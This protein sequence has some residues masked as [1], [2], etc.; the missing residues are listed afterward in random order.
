MKTAPYRGG[1]DGDQ[2]DGS[3]VVGAA[4]I[5][6]TY[7]RHG[8]K[9]RVLIR[10]VN[11][12]L[13][14]RV[15]PTQQDAIDLVRHF[16]RLGMAGVD[17]GQALAEARSTTRRAY[18]PLRDAL[19]ASLDEQVALRNL[20]ESTA[21]AYKNRLAMWV[22]PRLGE[23]PW[24]LISREEIGAIL[25]AIRKAG[26]S[27]A[28]VEQVRCP[29]TRFYQW[30][31]NV[32][33]YRGPNLAADLRFFI[34]KQPSKRARKRDLQWFRQAQTLLEACRELKPRWY[35]FLM[36]SFGGGLRW[37]EA[38]ALYKTD[39]DWAR[40]RVHVQ[41]TW[42]ED[43]GR[44]EPCKDGEDRWVK[45]PPSVLAALRVHI[46][47]TDLEGSLKRWPKERRQLVF[48]NTVGRVTRYGAFLELVW[49][50][51]LEA[52]KLPYRKPHAVRH[53]YA[54][55]MLEEG[56]DL[57]YVKDQLGHTS[58]EETE[59]TYGHLE[60]ERHEQRVDLDRVLAP[61]S[62]AST[63]VHA[64]ADRA[65]ERDQVRDFAS[66][67]LMVEGKGFEPSTSALRTPRSPN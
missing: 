50:P 25:L 12:P 38:T 7:V 64:A 37:G 62:C 13:I 29:L 63:G 18:P 2:G 6:A 42:S 60:R 44:M 27:A 1:R 39:L 51:L 36:V 30:Q 14:T 57:R 54:T 26:K 15:V 35:P 10:S 11:A 59:G 56:A 52:T 5:T 58:I 45:L 53:S 41:R 3:P 21:R 8:K 48:P 61:G 65:A 55:W 32:N 43:G 23:T 20:R 33:G 19:P 24:N 4:T 16:N 34:G 28:S 49:K 66:E 17:L 40:G 46:E 31:I 22:Y 47:A 9:W 67:V